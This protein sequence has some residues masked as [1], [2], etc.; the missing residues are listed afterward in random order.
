M[1]QF[2]VKLN[3]DEV[4]IGYRGQ[5]IVLENGAIVNDNNPFFAE[6][7][8]MSPSY[9]VEIKIKEETVKSV[10]APIVAPIVEEKESIVEDEKDM[11]KKEVKKAPKKESKK[12]TKKTSK[13]NKTAE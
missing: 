1:K 6:V 5:N 4:T 11:V 10:V 7:I 3:K 13:R 8:A 12:E 9:F 2:K